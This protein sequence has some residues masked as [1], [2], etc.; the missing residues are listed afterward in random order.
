MKVAL[1]SSG[2]CGNLP[3]ALKIT[4]AAFVFCEMF[5]GCRN[6]GAK[7]FFGFNNFRSF[8]HLGNIINY[9]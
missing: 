7:Q 2:P 3:F 4:F 1:L 8:A 6:K 9:I 5:L